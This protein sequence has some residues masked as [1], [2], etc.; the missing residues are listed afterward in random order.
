MRKKK[1]WSGAGRRW[2]YD[3]RALRAGY[4]N[5]QIHTFRLCDTH[6]FS[7]A[8]IVARTS[9]NVTLY[10]HCLSCSSLCSPVSYS[11]C[12][13]RTFSSRNWVTKICVNILRHRK[14]CQSFWCHVEDVNTIWSALHIFRVTKSD[15]ENAKHLQYV[16]PKGTL[17]VLH[18]IIN[19]YFIKLTA[20]PTLCRC[21]RVLLSSGGQ[22]TVCR[23]AIDGLAPSANKSD[24]VNSVS[25][26]V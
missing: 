21:W 4:L 5:L 12:T 19:V 17:E 6:C 25:P 1:L 26:Y 7:T 24:T 8:T 15:V 9:L 3:A 23:K 10:L 18:V 14:R 22:S 16:T 13:K 2:Q 20:R 11:I